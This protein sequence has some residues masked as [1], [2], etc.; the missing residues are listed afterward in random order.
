MPEIIVPHDE[1]LMPIRMGP[2]NRVADDALPA[3]RLEPLP[4]EDVVELYQQEW[5]G[6]D[7]RQLSLVSEASKRAGFGDHPKLLRTTAAKVVGEYLRNQ[8]YK[9]PT[10]ILDLGSGP[11]ESS[12]AI[13]QAIPDSLKDWVELI[14]LDPS[15]RSLQNA[16]NLLDGTVNNYRTVHGTD[17]QIPYYI[18]DESLDLITA[19][20]SVH[21]HSRIPFDI[22]VDALKPGGMIVIADWH[23]SV[24]EHPYTV[25]K[26]LEQFDWPNKQA[27]LANWQEAYPEARYPIPDEDN[28]LNVQANKDITAFW[29]GYYEVLKEHGDPGKNSIW[30]L[31]GHRLCER[32]IEGLI[33]AGFFVNTSNIIKLISSRVISSNPHQILPNSRLLMLTVAQKVE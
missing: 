4:E 20:A 23:N 1:D 26:F 2:P 10:S 5:A 28:P 7:F 24:W 31:E 3:W 12:L 19:V 18:D 30:P 33:E 17:L 9:E 25:M 6:G 14:L 11:G 16:R 21:H 29:L 13:Y 32:Y 22:Y 8:P 15:A 27:G